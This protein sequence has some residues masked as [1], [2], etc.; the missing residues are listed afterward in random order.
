MF[1][2]KKKI[3][4]KIEER[5]LQ[6]EERDQ[7]YWALVKRQFYKNRLAVWSLR[8]FY[9]IFFVAVFADFLANEKPI[10]AQL[11]GEVYFPV[12][13]GYAVDL[14]LSGWEDQ[15]VTKRWDE[16]D[17]DFVLFP[18][19]PYSATTIDV[20]NTDFVGPFDKQEVKSL[21]W[22]HWLGTDELGRDTAAG[23]IYGARVAIA[24]GVI[25]MSI[26]TIIGI[27]IGALAG[28]FGDNRLRMSRIR[29]F[30]NIIAFIAA[31]FYAFIA[32]S[33]YFSNADDEGGL[34]QQVVIS[35]LIFAGVF[36]IA[37]LL[38]SF[39][40]RIKWLGEKVTIPVDILVMRAIEILNSIPKLLLILSIVAITE[41]SVV[42]VMIIIGLISWTGI[43]RFIR[44][45]LLRVRNLEY[46]E[47]AQALG[48]SETRIIWK[49]AVPN[50]LTPVLIAIAFG[51]ASAILTEAFLSFLGIGLAAEDVTWGSLLNLARGKFAAWWLAIFPGFAIFITVTIFNL[52]GEGL[53]D[54]L[55]PRLKQ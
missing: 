21:R 33:Y 42:N 9:V 13:N 3:E 49:H 4:D 27:L 7:E 8:I 1:F 29:L 18:P 16:H 54:A 23:M 10:V 15:F 11:E 12:M 32:R 41:P 37:N 24:V 48:F 38:S 53:T 26:S 55:D 47:A 2:G 6:N 30:L 22:K 50:A 19:I 44:A 51:I 34:L 35:L 25:A 43:A 28:Y 46:I 20:F 31:L 17:Y 45:E 39:L 40:K 14:G 36:G 5:I 52:L